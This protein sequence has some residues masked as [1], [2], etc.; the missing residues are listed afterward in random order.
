MDKLRKYF[1][2]DKEFEIALFLLDTLNEQPQVFMVEDVLEQLY[3]KFGKDSANY[4]LCNFVFNRM[5]ETGYITSFNGVLKL[6]HEG[7]SYLALQKVHETESLTKFAKYFLYTSLAL[8]LIGAVVGLLCGGK[9]TLWIVSG[10]L[11]LVG[12]FVLSNGWLLQLAGYDDEKGKEAHYDCKVQY[13]SQGFEGSDGNGVGGSCGGGH[14]AAGD[15][16]GGWSGGVFRLMGRE[17]CA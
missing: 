8:M 1:P 13:S 9:G 4:H 11:I 15:C 5:K 12:V 16:D 7:V 2:T 14:R 10:V 6:A 3:E 17:T